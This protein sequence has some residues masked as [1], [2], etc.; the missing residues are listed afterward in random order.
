MK[1]QRDSGFRHSVGHVCGS[2]GN[3][4]RIERPTLSTKKLFQYHL[5]DENDLRI[6]KRQS[7][8]RK[9]QSSF[10]SNVLGLLAEVRILIWVFAIRGHRVALCR[11][12]GALTHALLDDNN[13]C[14]LVD[15]RPIGMETIKDSTQH[16]PGATFLFGRVAPSARKLNAMAI[17]FSSRLIY[18]ESIEFIYSYNKFLFLQNQ[19]IRDVASTVEN[20]N[21]AQLRSVHFHWQFRDM[22]IA[23]VNQPWSRH[24]S[25]NTLYLLGCKQMPQLD[26]VSIFIQGSL[27]ARW[28][29]QQI[30]S[31]LC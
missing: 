21:L 30:A 16:L 20:P 27:I 10:G 25:I 2:G 12:Y 8:P 29:Y 7:P 28:I 6:V 19:I 11:D 5:N 23:G 15:D 4:N 3:K 17:I 22:G 9:S 31:A 24:S 26:H 14:E 13:S 1:H 18:N